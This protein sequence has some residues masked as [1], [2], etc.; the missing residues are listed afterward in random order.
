MPAL[1]TGFSVFFCVALANSSLTGISVQVLELTK[2]FSVAQKIMAL[3]ECQHKALATSSISPS[4]KLDDVRGCLKLQNVHF[5]YPSRP[6]I[7]VYT[8][9]T[10]MFPTG[11]TTAIVGASGA[12][13]S[14]LILQFYLIPNWFS[15]R[16][17]I[18]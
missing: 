8:D 14:M 16:L 13:K 11:K 5:S 17:I 9:L 3:I 12:G 18:I 1:L 7:P 4:S 2:A 6:H 10:C 15:L